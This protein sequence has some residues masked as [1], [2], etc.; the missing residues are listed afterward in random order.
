MIYSRETE[1]ITAL[2][3]VYQKSADNETNLWLEIPESVSLSLVNNIYVQT[4]SIEMLNLDIT[5]ND[6]LLAEMAA[7]PQ[8]Q[9][10]IRLI[11][12]E[13]SETEEDGL[14]DLL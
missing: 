7:D 3:G 13:F 10:E 4:H 11:N 14:S 6:A 12:E 1:Q 5:I 9:N 8:I 2:S